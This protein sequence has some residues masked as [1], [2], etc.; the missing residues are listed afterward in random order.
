[1]SHCCHDH[2]T[3]DQPVIT[4]GK[5]T[6]PMHPE[7]IQ[8][9]P[10]SCPKCGMALEPM[11]VTASD[12]A[13]YKD[14][15]RRFW[16]CLALTIPVLILSMGHFTGARWLEF[17]LCTPVVLWGGGI[18][19]Q[20][21]WQSLKHRQLNMFTLIAL[22]VGAAYL[23]SVAAV[24]FPNA[25]PDSFRYQNEVAVYFEA[26]AVITVLVLLGQ[27]LELKARSRTSTALKDLLNKAPT[28]A[29]RIENNEERDIPIEQVQVNDLLRV[30]PGEKIPVDGLVVEGNSIVDESMI[31]GEPIPVEKHT[32]DKVTGGTINQMGT[33]LMRAEHVGSETLLSRIVHM[34]AEAQRSR[35]PIQKFADIVASYFVPIVIVIALLTFIGWATFGPEPRYAYALLNAVAVLIIACPCALGLA[36][37]MSIMVGMGRGAQVGVLIKNAEALEKLAKVNTI[38]TDKTGT[39]TEGKPQLVHITVTNKWKENDL[40]SLAASIEQFSEH[41]LGR[42][43][44]QAARDRKLPLHPI[45]NFQATSGGG[46]SGEID[47][48]HVLVG[49]RSYLESEGV[50]DLVHEENSQT[51]LFISI[52]KQAVG[53][54]SVSDPIKKSTPKAIQ[55]LHDRGLRIIL[56]TGDN[57]KTAKTIAQ[58][59]GI[60][61]VHAGVKP[62]EKYEFVKK[63]KRNNVVAMAGDGINDAPALAEADVGIAMGTGT[64]VAMESGNVT[65]V[66]GDLMGIVRAIILSH[67]MMRNIR[68]NL[69]LA[70]IYNIA[71]IPIA[72]GLL[73]PW[74]GWLLSPMLASAAMS[75]SSVSVIAN[76]LRLRKLKFFA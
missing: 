70:F 18:F 56:L 53:I 47:G 55:D 19:F 62:Q 71:S 21:A 72:A 73:Y 35:A 4:S 28:V 13:E 17:A 63:L 25:F 30:R 49:S 69:F 6:C 16:I 14:M 65:L 48:K 1:M 74:T 75:L 23:Y 40:L 60:D 10:G 66:K 59:L 26:A 43:L 38:V 36:T 76:A 31:T 39:L 9:G 32:G 64:D 54:F 67:A 52:D 5:Y 46:V 12:D 2:K 7:I 11:D 8:D 33:I 51:T 15:L 45:N 24:L 41:P 20:R 68:Q 57:P 27:V 3:H 29:H 58:Q 44:V 61:E 34:V 42:C 50:S 22:G 37:P